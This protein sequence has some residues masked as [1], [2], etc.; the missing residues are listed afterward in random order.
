MVHLG[1]NFYLKHYVPL[2]CLVELSSI[3]R[4]VQRVARFLLLFPLYFFGLKIQYKQSAQYT[5]ATPLANTTYGRNCSK[6]S[7]SSSRCQ[8]LLQYI[9]SSGERERKRRCGVCVCAFIWYTTPHSRNDN[10]QETKH[11][12]T[13]KESYHSF[14]FLKLV[15]LSSH[16][17]ISQ[18][19]FSF[20][21][22]TYTFRSHVLFSLL[23][24][25]L[26]CNRKALTHGIT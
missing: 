24:F 12:H 4:T 21:S 25:L 15:F 3:H 16:F 8:I 5:N 9:F 11:T 2:S 19:D 18:I 14:A 10:R 13:L 6:M 23:I 20:T 1:A 26:F 17:I 22:E 7:S